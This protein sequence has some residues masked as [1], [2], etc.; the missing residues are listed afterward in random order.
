MDILIAGVGGQGTI[1]ASKILAGAAIECGV[2]ARTGETIGMSQRGGCVVSHVRIGDN[3]S[4]YIPMGGADLLLSF[5]LCE[6]AR[7]LPQ[8]KKGGRAIINTAK[9]NPV[10]A[11]LGLMK[12]DADAI[13]KYISDN[14]DA[15]FIDANAIAIT[16]GSV[17]AVNSVMA[18]IAVGIGLL[19][20]P[21][22]AL[23]SAIRKNVPPKFFEM[24]VKAFGAG[25]ECAAKL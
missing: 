4:P 11:A 9:I 14:C 8:L 24:N 20:F 18:G 3:A 1:L 21:H 6:G 7:N 16:C 25:V 15:H 12:Y 10:T 22:D 23:I 17:K 2:T 19:D 5:E 13:I